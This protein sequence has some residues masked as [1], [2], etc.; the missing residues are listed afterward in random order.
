MAKKIVLRDL[1]QMVY[2]ACKRERY[3]QILHLE[4]G[5]FDGGCFIT[6]VALQNVLGGELASVRS[7][8]QP[9]QD[10]HILLRLNSQIFDPPAPFYSYENQPV[11]PF[12]VD[13][14]GV[15][16]DDEP[17]IY[18][19]RFEQV[20]EPF[21]AQTSWLYARTESHSCGMWDDFR[22]LRKA[23]SPEAVLQEMTE[24]FNEQIYLPLFT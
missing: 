19:K 1:D 18:M 6:A 7:R 10:Q 21:L 12:Y 14:N 5:P 22:C 4:C 24:Y 23:T 9:D 3:Y 11:Y 16:I 15:A 2:E 17:L 20:A 8:E 13:A